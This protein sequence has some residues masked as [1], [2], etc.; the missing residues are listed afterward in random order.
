MKSTFINIPPEVFE[1]GKVRV[2]GEVS[3]Y[4]FFLE[5]VSEVSLDEKTMIEGLSV[6]IRMGIKMNSLSQ[7]L[8]NKVREELKLSGEETPKQLPIN[9]EDKDALYSIFLAETGLDNKS[10]P[11]LK[12][13]SYIKWLEN[14]IKDIK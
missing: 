2:K 1:G 14:K 5:E 3:P 13:L 8:Q 7:D 10:T 4:F 11:E 6:C 12:T 9:S